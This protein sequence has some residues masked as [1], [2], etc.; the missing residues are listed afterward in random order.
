MRLDDPL[1]DRQSQPGALCLRGV[2]GLEYPAELLRGQT[3]AVIVNMDPQGGRVVER[4]RLARN[5]HDHWRRTSVQ[6][7]IENVRKRL[8]ECG[9]IHRTF[10]AAGRALL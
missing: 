1:Y 4:R 9:C 3:R 8:L 7:V 10:G 2:K 5:L 6:R